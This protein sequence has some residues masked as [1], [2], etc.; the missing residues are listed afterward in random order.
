MWVAVHFGSYVPALRLNPTY[1]PAASIEQ[2]LVHRRLLY[3]DNYGV[4]EALNEPGLSWSGQGLVVRGLHRLALTSAA[5]APVAQKELQQ[6]ALYIPRKVVAALDS[7]PASACVGTHASNGWCCWFH[8]VFRV[9][10]QIGLRCTADPSLVLLP[11]SC[12][13]PSTS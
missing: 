9:C 3:D 5:D 12:L 2:L 13:P 8:P 11:G 4:D 1:T 10:V 7:T 6:A